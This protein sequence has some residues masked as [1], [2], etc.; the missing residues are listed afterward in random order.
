MRKDLNI[1]KQCKRKL[2]D[3]VKIFIQN[4]FISGHCYSASILADIFKNLILYGY[5]GSPGVISTQVDIY[6]PTS[7]SLYFKINLN[8][9]EWELLSEEQKQTI[10]LYKYNYASEL[11]L[12][13]RNKLLIPA[14]VNFLFHK[15]L[16]HDQPISEEAEFLYDWY[17]GLS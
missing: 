1:Q 14:F 9:Q 2:E 8:S 7:K 4:P 11:P 12:Y 13:I 15:F 17:F 3:Y 6:H 16:K 10:K 5:S